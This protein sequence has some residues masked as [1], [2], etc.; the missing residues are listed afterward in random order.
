MEKKKTDI[1]GNLVNPTIQNV[2]KT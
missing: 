2:S 1:V